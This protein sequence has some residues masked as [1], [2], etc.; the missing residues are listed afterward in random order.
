MKLP[1]LLSRIS[2]GLLCCCAVALSAADAP[3]TKNGY[4]VMVEI[5]AAEDGTVES[6]ALLESEDIS[7]DDVLSK[8]ALAMALSTKVP[9]R[10]K[11]GKPVKATMRAPFFFPIEN[12]EGEA[13]N[14]GPKPKVKEAVQPAYP[15]NLREQG[16]VGGAILELV[17]DAT[18][19]LTRLTTLRASHPEFEAAARES[20]QRWTF[21]PAQLNGQPVESRTR[22]AFTFDTEQKMADIKW[23]ITP[24]PRLGSMIIIRPDQPIPDDAVAPAADP[25]APAK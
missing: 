22:F 12:D 15:L 25:A 18:G 24:R 7:A 14:T 20:M 13:A 17:V 5:K 16:V 21:T 19:K 4:T 11:D 6:V 3:A 23:R 10:L 1:R 8:M 2:V 9:P